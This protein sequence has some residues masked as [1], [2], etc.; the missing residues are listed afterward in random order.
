MCRYAN[1]AEES[2]I[3]CNAVMKMKVFNNYPRLCLFAKRQIN[4]GEEIRY[5]YGEDEETLV[6]RKKVYVLLH[7]Y[8]TVC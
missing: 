7:V 5:D 4:A 1:D 2:E 6:W 8:D 3:I